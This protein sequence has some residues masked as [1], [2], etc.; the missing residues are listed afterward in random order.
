MK[1]K[2]GMSESK[3]VHLQEL[4][5]KTNHIEYRFTPDDPV[6]KKIVEKPKRGL[7]DKENKAIMDFA[8][9][10]NHRSGVLI[11]PLLPDL[12]RDGGMADTL[13]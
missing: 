8:G 5:A 2:V 4:V 12:S 7:L 1:I 9:G 10:L 13:A 6:G 3:I 11:I